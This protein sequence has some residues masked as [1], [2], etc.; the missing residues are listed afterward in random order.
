MISGMSQTVWVQLFYGSGE[1]RYGP[2]GVDLSPFKT[3]ERDLTRAEER[4][5][6]V[7]TNWLYKAF[8]K[9][10]EQWKLLVMVVF[11][12]SEPVFWELM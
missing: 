10:E 6:G 2:E 12:N 4:P 5:W 3:V 9:D 11:N 1:I 7:I 8:R